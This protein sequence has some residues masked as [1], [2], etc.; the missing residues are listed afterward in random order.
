LVEFC[1][2]EVQVLRLAARRNKDIGGLDVAASDA[3]RVRGIQPIG[4]LDGELEQL[5]DM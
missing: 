1:Q 3:L 5:V 2:A 4:N